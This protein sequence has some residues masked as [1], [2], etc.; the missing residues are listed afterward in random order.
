LVS[1]RASGKRGVDLIYVF[2]DNIFVNIDKG[3]YMRLAAGK[4]YVADPCYV[5]AEDVYDRLLRETDYFMMNSVDR[6]GVM[7]DNVSGS[8]FAVFSTKYGDGSYRDGKGF[9]YGVDAGCIACIPVDI[10]KERSDNQYINEVEFT[11]DFEVRY[12]DGLI[13]FGDIIIN[14]D[15]DEYYED[16]EEE[17]EEY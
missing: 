7:V 8:Y 9:E 14:T 16:L 15:P 4:Y 2:G 1:S 12:E 5:L 3:Y 17:E 11:K 6:G 10:C 13:V